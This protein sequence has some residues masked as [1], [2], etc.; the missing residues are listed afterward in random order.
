M[1][2]LAYSNHEGRQVPMIDA[3]GTI[4]AFTGKHSPQ[5]RTP[6]MPL[7]VGSVSH[8]CVGAGYKVKIK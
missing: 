1:P 5:F 7:K 3:Q 8:P 4:G 6:V 2:R